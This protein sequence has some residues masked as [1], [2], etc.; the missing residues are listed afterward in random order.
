MYTKLNV[1]EQ[2]Q[3]PVK[4]EIAEA[5]SVKFR[6]IRLLRGRHYG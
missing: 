6:K 1:S 5:D 2:L 3:F 4:S